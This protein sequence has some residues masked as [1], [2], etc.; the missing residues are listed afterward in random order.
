MKFI[1]LKASV[2]EEGSLLLQA[3]TS[4]TQKAS[5]VASE[6]IDFQK[7]ETNC[8]DPQ[9]CDLLSFDE[10][11]ELEQSLEIWEIAAENVAILGVEA[12]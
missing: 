6:W 7:A 5:G 1:V 2:T 9:K 4:I 8:R 12:L 11:D 3:L 10:R